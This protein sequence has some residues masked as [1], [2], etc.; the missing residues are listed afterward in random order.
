MLEWNRVHRKDNIDKGGT[1]SKYVVFVSMSLNNLKF[2][3]LVV[4]LF[5]LN[6]F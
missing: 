1:I 5:V 2:L 6:A 4:I 3:Q